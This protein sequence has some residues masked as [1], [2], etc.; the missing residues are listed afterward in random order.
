MPN[1]IAAEALK[2]R[3]HRATW[4]L[5]WIFPIG[6]LIISAI[7]LLAQLAQSPARVAVD[8]QLWLHNATN[9]WDLPPGALGR[10]LIGSFAA[11]AFAGEYG[12][13]TWKLI[14][15]H[16][17]RASLLVAKYVVVLALV[18]AALLLAAPI[19]TAATWLEDVLKGDP[20]PQGLT[21]GALIAAHG[22]RLLGGLPTILFTIA[23][24][25]ATAVITR[26]TTA[27]II[28]GIV[29]VM[30]EQLFR[31]FAPGLALYIP[32]FEWLFEIAPGYHLA[33]IASWLGDGQGLLTPFASGHVVAYGLG[34]SLAVIAVWVA[35]LTGL[36]FWRF[37]RQDIN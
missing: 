17:S 35:A 14:V 26:S 28:V 15:P 29:Y 19:V 31:A 33:N 12:W 9:F 1:P 34:G 7:V 4:M 8:P 10:F 37:G 13:N 24:A 21:F 30:L 20:L 2:L 36:T 16:R 6:A 27:S 11:V 32:A 5:V 23:F 22:E 25:S 18:Y 3:R